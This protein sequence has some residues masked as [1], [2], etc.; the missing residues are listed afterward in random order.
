MPRG[1]YKDSGGRY[2]VSVCVRGQRVHRRLD[3]G[4]GANDAKRLVAD[5]RV[6]LGQMGG[7]AVEDPLLSD[8][9]GT[10]IEEHVPTLRSPYTA[11]FHALR[12]GPWIEGRRASEIEDVRQK[13]VGALRPRYAAATI[14]R[15]LLALRGALVLARRKDLADL[16]E[17]L[18]VRNERKVTLTI[19]EVRHLTSCA[20]ENVAAAIWLSLYTGCRRGEICKLQPKDIGADVIRLEAGNTKTLKYREVPIVPPVRP[21]LE[22]YVPLAINSEGVK[23]GFEGARKRAGMPHVHFH[24]IRRS[25]GTLLLQSGAPMHVV[26]K[27]LGH[28]SVR[29]TEARYAFLDNG[30]MRGALER[31]FV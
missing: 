11:K 25:C 30:T 13:I 5:L 26:S 10:Y 9:M 31:A 8:L 19:E 2:H 1:Y 6:D 29:V 14:S 4:M 18:P 3:A 17:P 7:N 21:Y 27:I 20:S 24:D 22:R 15:S 23:S 28:S 12:I 16:I